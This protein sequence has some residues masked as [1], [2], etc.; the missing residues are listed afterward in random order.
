MALADA[1]VSLFRDD[2][3]RHEV[4]IRCRLEEFKDHVE[5]SR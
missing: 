2:V 1:G 4:S 5:F 3:R